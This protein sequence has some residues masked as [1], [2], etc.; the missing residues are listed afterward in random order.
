M[1]KY[2][3]GVYTPRNKEKYIGKGVCNYR[4]GWEHTMM[5]YLDENPKIAKWCSE[6]LII[7]YMF[8][9]KQHKYFTDFYVQTVQ[10]KNILIEV[11]PLRETK[12]PRKTK[13][14][15]K[16]TL[17]YEQYTYAKNIAKWTA[18]RDYCKRRKIEFK[19]ITE[20]N[21]NL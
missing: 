17:L 10:G 16:S 6:C 12:P 2:Y 11:K 1:G 19:I 3:K 18:A 13:R 7:P 14:K 15:K 9:G 5:R 8:E 4:S 20:K 21:L